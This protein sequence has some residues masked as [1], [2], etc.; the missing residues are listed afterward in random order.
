MSK[1]MFLRGLMSAILMGS[2]LIMSTVSAEIKTYTGVGEYVMSD[3]ETP[4]IAKQR[5]K[6]RAEQNVQEQAGVFVQSYTKVKDYQ[7]TEQEIISITSGIMTISSTDYEV[8]SDSNVWT[9]RAKIK[10]KID[11]DKINDWL[12]SAAKSNIINNADGN[13]TGVIIDC[14]GLGLKA[15]MSPLIKNEQ[16]EPIYGHKNLNYDIVTEKGMASYA[17]SMTDDVSRAGSNPI[18]IKAVRLDGCNPVV[19]MLDA[20]KILSADKSDHFLGQCAVVF[21]K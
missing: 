4:E 5:A 1:K 6:L 12:E 13:Y 14:T 18:I 17:T 9:F 16:G 15:A 20:E 2:S 8:I 21:V 7:L 10:A 11:T 3:F 19:S